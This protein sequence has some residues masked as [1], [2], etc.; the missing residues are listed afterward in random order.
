MSSQIRIF[1]GFQFRMVKLLSTLL[2]LISHMYT[3]SMI[4]PNSSQADLPGHDVKTC[5]DYPVTIIDKT[6]DF[7]II[8]KRM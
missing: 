6:D 1:R 3:T 5:D 7:V 8:N 4:V 2:P